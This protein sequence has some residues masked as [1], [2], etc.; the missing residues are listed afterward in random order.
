MAESNPSLVPP[1]RIYSVILKPYVLNV[2]RLAPA[3]AMMVRDH[4]PQVPEEVWAEFMSHYG[5]GPPIHENDFD[6]CKECKLEK[7]RLDA[8]R[9]EEKNRIKQLDRHAS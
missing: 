3:F 2:H 5:G 9:T 6:E 8:R 1:W 4:R 7:E